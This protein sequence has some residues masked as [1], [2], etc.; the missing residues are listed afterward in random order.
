MDEARRLAMHTKHAEYCTCGKI[1]CGNGGKAG[2][3]YIHGI[4]HDEWI[5]RF[6]TDEEKQ[7]EARRRETVDAR[8]A[9]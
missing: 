5:L 7:R 3:R 4:V 1:V 2:H 9:K 6:G 8:K